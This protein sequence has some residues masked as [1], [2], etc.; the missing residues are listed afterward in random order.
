VTNIRN[1]RWLIVIE[2]VSLAAAAILHTEMFRLDPFN[3]VG[4]YEGTI[5]LVLFAGLAVIVVWP[6]WTR[7][8]AFVTQT[9]ALAGA[10]I[11]LY[12]AIRG[13]GPNSIPDLVFH[14]AIVAILIVGV[15][16]AWRLQPA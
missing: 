3:T 7:P 8:V 16:V 4:I 6:A 10:S 2:A 13:V 12:L 1:L 5:A 15:V 11:G 9:F 14:V